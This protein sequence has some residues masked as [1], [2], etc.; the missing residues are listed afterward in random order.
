MVIC[1]VLATFRLVAT[2]LAGN[3]ESAPTEFF[4]VLFSMGDISGLFGD[5]NELVPAS[6]TEVKN[7]SSINSA[8]LQNVDNENSELA[9]YYSPTDTVSSTLSQL[10]ILKGLFFLVFEMAVAINKR[11]ETMFYSQDRQLELFMKENA[12]LEE[13]RTRIQNKEIPEKI[14]NI[15]SQRAEQ[16]KKSKKGKSQR[17]QKKTADAITRLN[18]ELGSLRKGNKLFF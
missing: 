9:L 3:I 12:V 6:P 1:S 13:Q 11:C 18:M 15:E 5:K 4:S 8:I 16:K 14:K 2:P 7:S 17:S 10:L